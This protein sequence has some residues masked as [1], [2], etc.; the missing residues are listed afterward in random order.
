[1]RVRGGTESVLTQASVCMRAAEWHRMAVSATGDQLVGAVDGRELLS[2][3]DPGLAHGQAALWVSGAEPVHFDDVAAYSGP[4][5]GRRPTVLAHAI[6]ASDPGAQRFIDDQY[7]E[8]W[9]DESDQWLSGAGPS[10]WHTGHFW[11]DVE[12]TWE[13]G[14]LTRPAQLHI[15]VPPTGPTAAASTEYSGGYRLVITPT[16]D[17]RLSV[18]LHKGPEARGESVC[19][20]PNGPVQVTLRR[21]GARVEALLDGEPIARF[22]DEAPLPGGKVGLSAASARQQAPRLSITSSN[23]I[24]STFRSAPTEWSV[25]GG[26]WRVRSRW[27]CTPRWSW[28][29]GRS[30]HLA[31]I[32]TR[33]SFEG[34]VVVEFFGGFLMD[35]PFAPFYDTPSDINVTLCGDGANPGSGYSFIYGGWGNRATAI[36]RKGEVVAQTTD[37]RLPDTIDSLGGELFGGNGAVEL[38]KH[39]RHVRAERIGST[40]RF[41][42]DGKPALEYNDPDPLSGGS[43]G[44]WT[45]GNGITVARARVYFERAE[46]PRPAPEPPISLPAHARAGVKVKVPSHGA[47]TFERGL[48][49]WKASEPDSCELVLAEMEEGAGDRCLRVT[50]PAPGGTFALSAPVSGMDVRRRPLLSFDYAIPADVRVDVYAMI[51]DGKYRVRLTGPEESAPRIEDVGRVDEARADGRWR[52]AEVDLLGLLRPYFAAEEPIVLDDLRFANYVPAGYLMAGVGG[53]GAGA[54]YCLDNFLLGRA[55]A[56]PENVA[57]PFELDSTAS[58]AADADVPSPP[59]LTGVPASRCK[60]DFEEDLGCLRPWGVDSGAELRRTRSRASTVVARDWC[61][62]IRNTHIGGLFGVEA[63]C[64]PFEASRYPVLT[65]DYRVPDTLRVDLLVDV[66][67]SRRQIKF[68]D[69]DATWPVIGRIEAAADGQWHHAVVDLYG[70]LKLAFPGR[71]SLP[72]THLGFASTCWPG[73]RSGTAYW[74]DNFEIHA[75]LDVSAEGFAPDLVSRDESG[76]GAVSWLLDALPSTV[77]PEGPTESDLAGVLAEAAGQLVWLHAVGRD[78]AGNRSEPSHLP[79]RTLRTAD[80]TPPSVAEVSPAAGEQACVRGIA[81]TITDDASGV[82]PADISL[83]VNSAAYSIA[84]E[85]LEF[86]EA[87][88]RLTWMAPGGSALGQDGEDVRCELVARD[89]A[90][91]ELAA[92]VSWTWQVDYSQDEAPPPPPVVSYWPSETAAAN[93]FERDTGTWGNFV[94]CQV[95]RRAEGGATGPG[96]LELWDLRERGGTAYALIGD[97]PA[98]WQRFPMIRFSYRVDRAGSGLAL[99]L[100]ATTFDGRDD[101]WTPLASFPSGEGW[102]TASVNLVDALRAADPRLT[103]HRIFLDCRIPDSDGAVLVDDFALYSPASPGARFAWGEPADASGI[104]GYSWLLDGKDDTLPDATPESA[105]QQ[106][107]LTDLTPGHWCFHVRACDG[108]GNWGPATHLAFDVSPPSAIP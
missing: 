102:Q 82:S 55:T 105:E 57:V 71:T 77:P 48:G 31:S 27:A 108:A 4:I 41:I 21:A 22:E 37:F 83:T 52:Q 85:A 9:A 33:E 93:D 5:R 97:L 30:E 19:D 56:D 2:A 10:I 12:L 43:A 91:N 1:M 98:D 13:A 103:M 100:R 99:T 60:C 40:L 11:G 66:A 54:A 70:L 29:G 84:D 38:H 107:E 62:E 45:L 26:D 81:A 44:I 42:I 18:A 90:G 3:R 15:C 20:R 75:A 35:S 36:L 58:P 92:P 67:G 104:A 80:R 32:W 63:A 23:V 74:L 64:V 106:V 24:D 61:L 7:M 59:E 16:G 65:F 76:V 46:L 86:D 95:L 89:L 96:C 53:N 50:N 73:N 25:V 17:N 78:G 68:T 47:A 28:F 87:S 69:N 14:D 88:G 51:G 8:G 6:E 101:L 79:L 49:S 34:D 72:V 39:W 94:S